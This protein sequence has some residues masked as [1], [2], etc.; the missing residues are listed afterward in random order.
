[1]VLRRTEP[2]FDAFVGH[3]MLAVFNRAQKGREN[4]HFPK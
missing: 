2:H 1:M 4:P 3:W